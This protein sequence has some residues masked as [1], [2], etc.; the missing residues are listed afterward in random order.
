MA[1]SLLSVPDVLEYM[2]SERRAGAS[3][4]FLA[5]KYRVDHTTIIYH[6]KKYK[7]QPLFPLIGGQRK[8]VPVAMP[9]PVQIQ[10]MDSLE[11]ALLPSDYEPRAHAKDYHDYLEEA[12]QQPEMKHYFGEV[13]KM[14]PLH[15]KYTRDFRLIREQGTP[16]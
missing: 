16:A 15:P 4:L 14:D 13:Y 1:R 8:K 12:M 10:E 3:L 11:E 2:L 6:C 9:E 5:H 7:I